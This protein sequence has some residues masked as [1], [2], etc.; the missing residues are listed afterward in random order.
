MAA[1]SAPRLRQSTFAAGTVWF[2][3]EQY[4][5]Y[6]PVCNNSVIAP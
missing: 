5:P 1:A 6:P 2:P 3:N 4:P